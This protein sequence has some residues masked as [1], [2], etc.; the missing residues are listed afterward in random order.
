MALIPKKEDTGTKIRAYLTYPKLILYLLSQ[1]Y[2]STVIPKEIIEAA[3]DD[4]DNI[5][6][7]S[8]GFNVK[9]SKAKEFFTPGQ[10]ASLL[11]ASK[12]SPEELIKT[13]R[14]EVS[15]RKAKE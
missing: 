14:R 13:F 10:L 4:I 12:K 6:R 9:E 1:D 2:K 5:V 11:K 8:K 7:L 3:R 15:R